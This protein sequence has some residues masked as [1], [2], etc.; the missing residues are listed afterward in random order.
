MADNR[1]TGNS[2]AYGFGKVM[3]EMDHRWDQGPQGM[4]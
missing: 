4:V 1:Y 3:D 2:A